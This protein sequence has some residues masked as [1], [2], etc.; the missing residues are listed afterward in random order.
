M[1]KTVSAVDMIAWNLIRRRKQERVS[2]FFFPSTISHK[3][4]SSALRDMKTS[5]DM[6]VSEQALDGLLS[7]KRRGGYPLDIFEGVFCTVTQSPDPISD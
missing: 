4:L 7:G 6:L 2:P 3:T 1:A 5:E